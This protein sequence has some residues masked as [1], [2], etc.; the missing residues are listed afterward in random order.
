LLVFSLPEVLFPKHF[1]SCRENSVPKPATSRLSGTL[2][3]ISENMKSSTINSFFTQKISPIEFSKLINSEVVDYERQMSKVGSSVSLYLEENE[4][5][6]IDKNGLIHLLT[7][8][9]LGKLN[10]IELAY[11]CDC[12]TLAE[13]IHYESE[14]IK[15]VIFDLADP[16]INGG[17]KSNTKLEEIISTLGP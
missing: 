15:D 9:T 7:S 6:N 2:W 8:T 1:L 4:P 12:F 11:I 5:I 14:D 17:Y 13:E 10:N 16:E 3:A